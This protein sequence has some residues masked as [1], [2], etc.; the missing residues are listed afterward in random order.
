M[1]KLKKDR[2]PRKPK[3]FF[4]RPKKD[5]Y[6]LSQAIV[7][8]NQELQ[9]QEASLSLAAQESCNVEDFYPQEINKNFWSMT[10]HNILKYVYTEIVK[11]LV[12]KR[13]KKAMN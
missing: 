7:L 10:Y 13:V 9:Y 1:L 12:K 3:I 5:R 2:K 6:S 8:A 11:K 4:S